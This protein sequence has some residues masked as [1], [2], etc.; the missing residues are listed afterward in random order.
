M[1]EK[2]MHEKRGE[3]QAGRWGEKKKMKNKK[4]GYYMI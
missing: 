1:D 3:R 2:S 4:A